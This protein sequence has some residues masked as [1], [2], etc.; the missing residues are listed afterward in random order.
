[1]IQY[2][3]LIIIIIIYFNRQRIEGLVNEYQYFYCSDKKGHPGTYYR[4]VLNEI[5]PERH[6]FYSDLLDVIDD[7][8]SGDKSILFQTPLCERE[9][10]YTKNYFN[11]NM[12]MDI[13]Y[14]NFKSELDPFSNKNLNNYFDY[15]DIVYGNDEMNLLIEEKERLDQ[16]I[17]QRKY[18]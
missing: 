3:L 16:Y 18:E 8:D 4:K 12:I 6:G 2:I 13:K 7:E 11:D 5:E 9:Y 10:D 17:S 14:N 15:T 1:M